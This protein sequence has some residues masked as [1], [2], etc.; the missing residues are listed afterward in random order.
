MRKKL[1]VKIGMLFGVFLLL[2]S[3]IAPSVQAYTTSKS[4]YTE[5]DVSVDIKQIDELNNLLGKIEGV[6]PTEVLAQTVASVVTADTKDELGNNLVDA[7]G[8]DVLKYSYPSY[9][10]EQL[11]GVTI[12]AEQAVAWLHHVGY[13]ATLLNR[14]LTTDEIKKKLDSSTPII[15][16]LNNQQTSN[17]LL[18]GT[19]G[20]L[21]AHDDVVTEAETLNKSF[22]QAIN[23]GDAMIQDGEETQAFSFNNASKAT[24]P[25]QRDDTYLW[26]QTITD[27]KQDPTLVN[28]Q[29]INGNVASGVFQS[30]HNTAGANASVEFTDP[31][32]TSATPAYDAPTLSYSTYMQDKA[33]MAAVSAGWAGVP[34]GTLRME[35]FKASLTHLPEGV[36]GGISYSTSVQGVGWSTASDGAMAGTTG[37]SKLIEAIK[38]NLTGEL[39]EQYDIYYSGYVESTG[40]TAYFKNGASLGTSGSGKKLKGVNIFLRKKAPSPSVETKT[41]AVKLINLYEDSDH[42]KT[43]ADLDTYSKISATDPITSE[44]IKAWYRYLGFE[45]DEQAGRFSKEKAMAVNNSGRLYMTLFNAENQ[46]VALKNYALIGAGYNYN[47]GWYSPTLLTF[48][49]QDVIPFVTVQ[50]RTNELTNSSLTTERLKAWNDYD[51][52]ATQDIEGNI[53]DK[54]AEELTLYN[55]RAK[56]VGDK[57]ELPSGSDTPESPTSIT[58]TSASYNKLDYFNIRETQEQEPWCS[59]YIAAATINTL[60]KKI[61]GVDETTVTAKELMQ[62]YFPGK[63]DDELSTMGGGTISDSLEVLKNKYNVTAEVVNRSLSFEEVKAQ[64]D[65]GKTVQMDAYDVDSEEAQGNGDNLGHSLSIVG[66]VMPSNGD[67]TTNVPYYEVWNP[68]WNETFYLSANAETFNLEGTNYKWQRTWYNWTN[69]ATN[70]DIEVSDDVADLKV[71]S[72]SNPR[73]IE[74]QENEVESTLLDRPVFKLISV[75]CDPSPFS[76]SSDS[77]LG[78]NINNSTVSE[79]GKKYSFTTFFSHFTYGAARSKDGNFVYARINE[80]EKV[81]QSNQITSGFINAYNGLQNAQERL[82]FGASIAVA[83]AIFAAFTSI[84]ASAAVEAVLQYFNVKYSALDAINAVKDCFSNADYA[85]YYFSL[86]KNLN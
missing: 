25:M 38:I 24:D 57:V 30:T 67:T 75:T 23:L 16:I 15:T 48:S 5:D 27:I 13:T 82:I 68:W 50:P 60:N 52:F 14:P 22:I 19:A 76:F 20:V 79:W 47:S 44:Q 31:L 18:Q 66:Y 83:M 33:W 73:I 36:T 41:A 65:S 49:H 86:I 63:T 58:P 61:S 45:F 17:W 64:I 26:T 72:G 42:Q 39:A 4:I 35:A 7:N 78:E 2:F 55:I 70:Q 84:W 54:Y 3:S 1:Y 85:S 34:G 43:T 56:D 51:F 8:R 11:K 29:T 21:Y 37:Q 28:A 46:S 62:A 81:G 10:E 32:V 6:E 9:T 53:V 74:P 40:Y 80:R 69:I 59:E 12:N 71:A 77:L